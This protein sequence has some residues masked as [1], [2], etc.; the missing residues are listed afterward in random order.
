VALLA[1]DEDPRLVDD[2][3]S[4]YEVRVIHHLERIPVP[5]PFGAKERPSDCDVRRTM[6]GARRSLGP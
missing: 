3:A 1:Q 4:R 6:P 2:L 5:Y